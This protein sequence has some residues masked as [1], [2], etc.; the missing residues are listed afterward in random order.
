[1]EKPLEFLITPIDFT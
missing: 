1:M